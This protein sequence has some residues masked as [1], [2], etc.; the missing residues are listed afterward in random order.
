[1]KRQLRNLVSLSPPYILPTLAAMSLQRPTCRSVRLL[2]SAR[3][4]SSSAIRREEVV[5]LVGN[6][7]PPRTGGFRYVQLAFSSQGELSA[8]SIGEG[9]SH[10]PNDR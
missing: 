1:M 5:G 3:S 4:I 6:V 7:P 10:T 9:E 8:D 2:R